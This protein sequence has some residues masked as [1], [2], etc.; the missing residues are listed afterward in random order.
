MKSEELQRLRFCDRILRERIARDD[1]HRPYWEIKLRIANYLINRY[2]DADVPDE[3]TPSESEQLDLLSGHPLLQRIETG[4]A[5]QGESLQ[6]FERELHEK[7][8]GYLR[9]RAR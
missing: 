8:R 7:V 1:D 2:G 9:K 4:F 3:A 6:E 5:T